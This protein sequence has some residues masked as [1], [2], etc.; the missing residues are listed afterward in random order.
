MLNRSSRSSDISRNTPVFWP[1]H[2]RRSQ[3]SPVNFGVTGP[4][5]T[6]FLHDIHASYALILRTTRPWY[7]NSFS[8]TAAP[9]ASGV[10]RCRYIFATLFGCHG[11][12]PW[13]IGKKATG[14]SFARNALSYGVKIAKIGPV[15]PK[16]LDQISPFLAVSYQTFTN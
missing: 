7:Y 10:S 9:N 2:T 14:S 15:D 5:F 11:N 6:K 1:R 13:Q 4:N 16:I 3:M 8:S 12:I